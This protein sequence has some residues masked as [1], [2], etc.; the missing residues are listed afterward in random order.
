MKK[1]LIVALFVISLASC[2]KEGV[3]VSVSQVGKDDFGVT[4]LFEKD[5]VQVYRFEDAGEYR[6][7]T[8]GNGSFQPQVQKRTISNG[9]STTTTTWLDGA[10]NTYKAQNVKCDIGKNNEAAIRERKAAE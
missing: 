6:Y 3:P 10:S 8:I 1:I 4:F 5:G 2:A 7:F 9:K